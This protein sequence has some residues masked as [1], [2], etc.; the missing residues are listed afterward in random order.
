VTL[1][2]LEYLI[3]VAEEGSFTR[4]AGR[5][6]VSQP[7]LSHQVKSLERDLGAELF[8][9]VPEGVRLTATGTAFLPHARATVTEAAAAADAARAAAAL[10]AGEV[11]L[12]TLYSIALG[13]IPSALHAW[14]ARHPAVDVEIVEF[15]D[16]EELVASMGRGSVDVGV[17]PP[18]AEWEGPVHELGDEEFVLVLPDGDPLLAEHP[19]TLPLTLLAERMW[20]LYA[21]ESGLSRVVE[22]ACA[23]A[24][25]IP[26]AA[27]QTHHTVTAVELAAAGMGP[28]L[29]PRN[30]IGAE[31]AANVR[32]AETPVRRRLVAFTRDDTSPPVGAFVAT[33]AEHATVT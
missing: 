22:A 24:G 5:L 20:V 4:A 2:Q 25:F 29:V 18:P 1:R 26:R 23:A 32:R 27:V 19:D 30:V 31:F 33:L 6:F 14:R 15:L 13:V 17:G 12:G 8:E 21:P 7:A 10:D 11:R 3:A 16:V 28:A 9:R